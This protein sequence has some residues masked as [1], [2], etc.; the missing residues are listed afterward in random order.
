MGRSLAC[1]LLLATAARATDP[2][3]KP[4][5]T[6]EAQ[7]A[8]LWNSPVGDAIRAV[9]DN[10][11]R[12]ALAAGEAAGVKVRNLT[13]VRIVVGPAILDGKTGA[14]AAV[15]QFAK[16]Y[17]RAK[18]AETITGG[19]GK[20][21]AATQRG[22]L[23]TGEPIDLSD[24]LV[25]TVGSP[26][27]L[28]AADGPAL[29]VTLDL[30]TLVAAEKWQSDWPADY[31]PFLPLVTADTAAV[32]V[33]LKPDD[34]LTAELRFTAADPA[35]VAACAKALAAAVQVVKT[36]A[37]VTAAEPG[38]AFFMVDG[39]RGGAPIA[40]ALGPVAANATVT[41]D[42]PTAVLA[43]T[44]PPDFPLAAVFNGILTLPATG[45]RATLINNLKQLTL[46]MHNYLD[47]KGAFPASAGVVDKAGKPLL[48]WRVAILPYLEQDHLFKQFKLDEP[49]DSPANKLVLANNP[50]P[51]VFAVPG[52]TKPGEKVTLI[53]GFVG[54]GAFF[55]ATRPK[56]IVDITDG[57]S[58][59]VM[60][61]LSRDAVEWTKP[62]DIPFDPKADPRKLVLATQGRPPASMAAAAFCDG[63]VRLLHLE[64]SAVQ[65]IGAIT[66]AGGEVID[67]EAVNSPA[68]QPQT[69]KT[70]GPPASGR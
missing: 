29:V 45:N 9:E 40:K 42:G 33:R 55:D 30:A 41:T 5:I 6:V 47:V 24:P 43:F 51:A 2:P 28:D 63:S 1:L 38:K 23:P 70:T 12:Q 57:T 48:S 69:G 32:V 53:Q 66:A 67:F 18:L 26:G 35:K 34:T 16:P 54:N 14:V 68:G 22:T 20:I 19:G 59:T 15:G 3:A 61:T 49:W 4:L 25:V 50:M 56:R 13:R 46:A 64:L 17:E 21:D 62:A 10:G 31:K 11:L 8:K 60:M 58:N 37:V 7:V 65:W 39:L 52:V 27:Q 44:L 36:V